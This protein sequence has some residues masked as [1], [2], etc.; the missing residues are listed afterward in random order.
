M[1]VFSE[2]NQGCI[3][4]LIG[5]T[6]FLFLK[7][8]ILMLFWQWFLVPVFSITEI[9]FFQSMGL[10]F[11]LDFLKFTKAKKKE[12]PTWLYIIDVIVNLG[13]LLGLGFIIHSFLC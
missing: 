4:T 13:I 6:I 8:T 7:T 2:N 3:V 5:G 1:N 10:I 11:V 9:T 12:T